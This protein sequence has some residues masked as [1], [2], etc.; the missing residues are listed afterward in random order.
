MTNQ[1]NNRHPNNDFSPTSTEPKMTNQRNNRYPNN[2]FSPTSTE[3]KYQQQ[4]KQ[5]NQMPRNNKNSNNKQKNNIPI[6]NTNDNKTEHTEVV[7][8]ENNKPTLNFSKRDDKQINKSSNVI[9]ILRQ[10]K[11]M[12]LDTQHVITDSFNV[13]LPDWIIMSILYYISVIIKLSKSNVG[14]SEIITRSFPFVSHDG[15]G[16]DVNFI[17]KKVNN[18]I[19]IYAKVKKDVDYVIYSVQYDS[20][21]R[22]YIKNENEFNDLIS[23]Q[24][25]SFNNDRENTQGQ[26]LLNFECDKKSVKLEEK[27]SKFF[28]VSRN[29]LDVNIDFESSQYD[30]KNINAISIK[31]DVMS[32]II[33]GKPLKYHLYV[34]A[35]G[36]EYKYYL[37]PL[38]DPNNKY[39]I[40]ALDLPRLN[41]LN[42]LQIIG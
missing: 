36:I 10:Y 6:K 7:L 13:F 35:N 23:D 22:E 33:G 39:E 26:Y 32:S 12:F 14:V 29:V 30:A 31:S 3:P 1:R 8:N 11:M 41:G 27:I 15:N 40:C 19:K 21:S 28:N 42:S 9:Q 16:V 17:I 34:I 24:I 5:Q 18:K 37:E 4:I 25:F 38:N 20:N 2:D